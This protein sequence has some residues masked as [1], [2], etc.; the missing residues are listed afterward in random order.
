[1]EW[2]TKDGA[3]GVFLRCDFSALDALDKMKEK[4][5]E[6]VEDSR[7]YAARK[8]KEGNTEYY[9]GQIALCEE[10][11]GYLNEMDKSIEEEETI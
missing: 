11:L 7:D 1:M 2:S 9:R 8:M 10:F 4:F 6:E 3:Y 5:V